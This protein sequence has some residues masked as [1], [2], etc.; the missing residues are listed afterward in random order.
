[1]SRL[2]DQ[3]DSPSLIITVRSADMVDKLCPDDQLTMRGIVSKL[4]STRLFLRNIEICIAIYYLLKINLKFCW[5]WRPNTT[6][7]GIFNLQL[8]IVLLNPIKVH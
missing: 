5:I 2:C 3:I 4:Y 7:I 6:K 8:V 1:M